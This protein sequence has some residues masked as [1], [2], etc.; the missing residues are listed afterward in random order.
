M[1]VL[2]WLSEWWP[3]DKHILQEIFVLESQ[4]PSCGYYWEM[5]FSVKTKQTTFQNKGIVWE[6]FATNHTSLYFGS[7]PGDFFL[8]ALAVLWILFPALFVQMKIKIEA[9]NFQWAF[10]EDILSRT[11][12]DTVEVVQ[13]NATFISFRTTAISQIFSRCGHWSLIEG[14]MYL[15]WARW[16]REIGHWSEI[17]GGCFSEVLNALYLL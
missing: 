3:D 14:R 1:H 8:V 4:L 5:Q 11:K 2:L 16:D 17:R 15:F 12:L 10:S 7:K 9:S 6:V 13:Y